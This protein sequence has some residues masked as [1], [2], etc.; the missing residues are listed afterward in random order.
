MY[1]GGGCEGR[2]RRLQPP[3]VRLAVYRRYGD[4]SGS[5]YVADT[6]NLPTGQTVTRAVSNS[7]HTPGTTAVSSTSEAA[8]AWT[9]VKR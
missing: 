5:A 7:A 1:S 6:I 8:T 9:H 2:W 4:D 3:F